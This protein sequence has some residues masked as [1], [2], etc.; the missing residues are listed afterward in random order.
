MIAAAEVPGSSRYMGARVGCEVA[1]VPAAETV[2]SSLPGFLVMTG[3]AAAC[4]E[5]FLEAQPWA[6]S[7]SPTTSFIRTQLLFH[8]N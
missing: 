5:W 7:S 1:L 4:P 6:C 3:A 2:A 8:V